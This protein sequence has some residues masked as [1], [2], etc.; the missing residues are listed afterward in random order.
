MIAT[1]NNSLYDRLIATAGTDSSHKWI[2]IDQAE[3]LIDLVVEEC[4]GA[5]NPVLRDM[6][7]RGQ[8][9]ELMRQHFKEPV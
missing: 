8:A 9:C 3:R 1:Q 5:L 2:S 4:C 7:S 6:I